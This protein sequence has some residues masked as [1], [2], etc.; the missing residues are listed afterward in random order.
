M[1]KRK[2]F[3]PLLCTAIFIFGC[4]KKIDGSSQ[5][6][7]KSSLYEI[8]KS[9]PD[10][11]RRE[12]RND[13]S[14]VEASITNRVTSEVIWHNSDFGDI[15]KIGVE[16]T[17]NLIIGELDKLTVSD[18]R[19]MAQ[20][21]K[22]LEVRKAQEFEEP[23]KQNRREAEMFYIENSADMIRAGV[24]ELREMIRAGVPEL[25]EMIGNDDPSDSNR[26]YFNEKISSY[27]S[28][29]DEIKSIALELGESF[30]VIEEVEMLLNKEF[31]NEEFPNRK[32]PDSMWEAKRSMVPIED[33]LVPVNEN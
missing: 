16:D 25:R 27:Y 15:N 10:E 32:I 26:K 20:E 31:S 13:L 1:S 30:P 9:M 19:K 24:P 2:L 5:D 12:F 22:D 11:E 17:K 8:M 14:I 33:G 18:I 7:Y 21:Q 23:A 28:K 6:S 29:L 4:E 3:L